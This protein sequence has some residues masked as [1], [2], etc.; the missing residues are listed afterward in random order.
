MPAELNLANVCIA[1]NSCFSDFA[2]VKSRKASA[3]RSVGDL[4]KI[5]ISVLD[6]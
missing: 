3:Q 4:S 2:S 1:N 6:V 5:S